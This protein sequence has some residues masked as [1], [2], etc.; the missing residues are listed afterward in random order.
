VNWLSDQPR[1]G[2]PEYQAYTG[3]TVTQD[4]LRSDLDQHGFNHDE[5]EVHIDEYAQKQN[6]QITKTPKPNM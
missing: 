3:K 2:N 1:R 6:T 5:A 4:Q